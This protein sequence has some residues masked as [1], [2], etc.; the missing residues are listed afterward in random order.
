ME[1]PFSRLTISSKSSVNEFENEPNLH[2]PIT[3]LRIF[4][5]QAHLS[6]IWDLRHLSTMAGAIS[7]IP[8]IGIPGEVKNRLNILDLVKDKMFFTLYVRALGE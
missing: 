6:T 4:K 8:L 5:R 7:S 1:A 2:L 3:L